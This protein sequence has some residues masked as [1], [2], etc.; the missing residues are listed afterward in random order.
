MFIVQPVRDGNV[1]F[2]PSLIPS[3]IP[4]DEKDRGAPR[5]ERIEDSIGLACMLNPE[6]SHVTVPRSL[7][8]GTVR[9]TERRS[10][11]FEQPTVA[12]ISSCSAH[13]RL[14]PLAKFIGVFN[15]P[16]HRYN[17]LAV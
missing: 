14:P 6:F 12:A 8:T 13:S 3:L 4:S 2:I 11:L 17:L 16:G 15:F 10:I 9:E 1:L 7:D 5:V